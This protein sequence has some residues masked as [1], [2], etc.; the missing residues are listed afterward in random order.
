MQKPGE[1]PPFL[2]SGSL[3]ACFQEGGEAPCRFS[4]FILPASK[5]VQEVCRA[6]WRILV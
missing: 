1:L 6:S 4:R 2:L 5:K 3:S